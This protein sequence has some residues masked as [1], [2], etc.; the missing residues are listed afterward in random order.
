M[1]L[2]GMTLT[3]CIYLFAACGD[4]REQA[5][6]PNAGGQAEGLATSAGVAVPDCDAF[7]V[8]P[9]GKVLELIDN[10]DTG[11]R[12]GEAPGEVTGAIWAATGV[13]GAG[14][15]GASL[16]IYVAVIGLSER[17]PIVFLLKSSSQPPN[18]S[19]FWYPTEPMGSWRTL[20]EALGA[21]AGDGLREALAAVPIEGM[22][23]CVGS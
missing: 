22:K 4:A 8:L 10:G 9:T 12:Y 20:Q 5:G 3:I 13:M 1:I 7:R 16:P 18:A 14:M 19:S 2:R 17:D 6:S 15:G 11:E 21:P 23:A